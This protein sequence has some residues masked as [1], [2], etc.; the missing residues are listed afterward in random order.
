[1]MTYFDGKLLNLG[2]FDHDASDLGSETTAYSHLH[3]PVCHILANI[4]FAPKSQGMAPNKLTIGWIFY[5]IM[6]VSI[7]SRMCNVMINLDVLK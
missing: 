6:R 7:C 5:K 1:M 2:V 3:D 4:L